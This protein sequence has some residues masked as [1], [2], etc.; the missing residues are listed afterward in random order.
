MTGG[1][2]VC[3]NCALKARD[4]KDPPQPVCKA[5]GEKIEPGIFRRIMRARKRGR[6]APMMCRKCF[7]KRR[8]ERFPSSPSKSESLNLDEW[9][10]VKCGASLEPDEVN[11][12][13][14]GQSVGCEYCG[15]TI[16]IDLFK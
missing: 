8:E 16:T 11:D 13:K 4:R 12:I 10:C 15:T 7:L 3:R 2:I 5:C 14:G 9:E 1:P 6:K